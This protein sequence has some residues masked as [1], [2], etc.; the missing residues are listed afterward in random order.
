VTDVTISRP[1][2]TPPGSESDTIVD[3][4]GDPA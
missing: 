2:G 3:D 4:H 1:A